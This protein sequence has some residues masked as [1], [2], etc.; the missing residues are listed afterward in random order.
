MRLVYR[1]LSLLLAPFW[2]LF[3]AV[4][5]RGNFRLFERLGF[6]ESRKDAPIWIQAVSVGEVRIALRLATVL[7]ARG[8][9]VA[10]TSTTATGLDLAVKEGAPDLVPQA[11]P[12]DIPGCAKR[13]VKRLSPRALVLVETEIWPTLFRE[14]RASG[15]PVFIVNARLSDRSFR[16]TQ[17]FKTL[18]EKALTD[19]FIAAQSEEHAARFRIL[20][21]GSERIVV[22]GNLKYDLRPP[23]D[24]ER[25]R[26]TLARGLPEAPLWVAGSVRE[27]EEALVLEAHA[28]VRAAVPGARLILAPRHLNRAPLCLEQCQKLGLRGVER[29]SGAGP[30]W[31]VLILDTVGELWSAYALGTAAF[32]GGS[33]VPLGGQNVLEPAF[34]GKPVLFGP[35][36][37]NFREDAERLLAGSGAV[38][39]G[40]PGELAERVAEFLT[41]PA[42]ADLCGNKAL[43][44]VEAHR[45]AVDRTAK[46]IADTIPGV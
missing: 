5:Q 18:Y 31:D 37:E 23:E 40:T 32:V 9:P 34:L 29:T 43:L 13:A 22:L 11:F 39:V 30:D 12:V 20:G 7:K 15:V 3:L 44:A 14:A 19:V 1:T 6:Y 17:K 35:H 10:L 45:G 25:V 2:L 16:R 33:L 26:E 38:R 36:T 46:W 28:A 41:E 24:F 4:Q 42:S 21:A 27:G 8:L